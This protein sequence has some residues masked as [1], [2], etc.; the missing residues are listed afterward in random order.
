LAGERQVLCVVNL[1]VHAARLYGLLRSLRPVGC[2]H[3]STTMCPRH[4]LDALARIREDLREGGDCRV[5]ST[6]LVEAGVDLD[7][8]VVYRAMGPLDSVAQAAG[9]CDREGKLTAARGAAGG[10]VIVFEPE[11]DGKLSTPRGSYTE[12]TDITRSMASDPLAIDEPDDVRAYF[13]RYYDCNQDANDIEALRVQLNFVEVAK[14]FAMIEGRT[15]AV[16]VPYDEGAR[17]IERLRGRDEW[18]R[19]LARRLQG[20]QVGLYDLELDAARRAGAVYEVAPGT[21][22]WA[23]TPAHY[24]E[25]LGF[26]L[27]AAEQL[28]VV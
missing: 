2:W 5:V 13:D 25:E 16:L 11:V 8:P 17:L 21:D 10:R 15:R 27:E 14:R 12:A 18:N 23:T 7:F 1:R 26:R 3:L 20:Y 22:V 28:Y 6:Q 4:R 19:P 24:D 9:R